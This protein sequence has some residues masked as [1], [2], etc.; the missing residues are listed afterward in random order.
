MAGTRLPTETEIARK[1][2]QL[3]LERLPKGWA[4]K[5]RREVGVD[6]GQIDR[7]FVITSP[8][9]SRNDCD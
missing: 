1:V 6:R 3:L 2:E 5:A 4:L 9:R 7:V 8:A